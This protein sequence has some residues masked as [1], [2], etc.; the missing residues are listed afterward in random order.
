[1]NEIRSAS[2][3]GDVQIFKLHDGKIQVMTE[4]GPFQ[5]KVIFSMKYL[6]SKRVS[7]SWRYSAVETTLS[8]ITDY[9]RSSSNML[10]EATEKYLKLYQGLN[11][12]TVS[13]SVVQLNAILEH[14]LKVNCFVDLEFPPLSASLMTKRT[15]HV[16]DTRAFEGLIWKRAMDFA[17]YPHLFGPAI[18]P[19]DVQQGKLGNCGFAAS[20]TAIAAYPELIRKLFLFPRIDDGENRVNAIGLYE[21]RLC[22]N[23][24]WRQ[25][26]IDDLI[27][28]NIQSRPAFT[29]HE[30]RNLLWVSLVEKCA[31]KAYGGYDR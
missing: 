9:I 29:C 21:V 20:L 18:T 1:M 31:A 7:Y 30:N 11:L 8:D 25:Y 14:R 28:C 17:D 22:H 19:S 2:E 3:L 13:D 6:S 15:S 10:E 27:P 24:L 12:Q 5:K 26:T 23:G 4:L 16:M